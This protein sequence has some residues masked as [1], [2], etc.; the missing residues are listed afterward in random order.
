MLYIFIKSN[1]YSI[2]LIK[3]KFEIQPKM[4]FANPTNF[5]TGPKRKIETGKSKQKL[6]GNTI[7]NVEYILFHFTY[8]GNSSSKKALFFVF[9]FD[10]V[11]GF[12]L[13]MAQKAS[14]HVG[15]VSVSSVIQSMYLGTGV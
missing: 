8:I 7:L 1:S 4:F 5:V 11:F 13:K 10:Q 2:V 9:V 6:R 15:V 12:F 3:A 14:Q